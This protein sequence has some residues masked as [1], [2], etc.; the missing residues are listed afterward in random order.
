MNR[1]KIGIII[2]ILLVLLCIASL[3]I[4][5]WECSRFQK[6]VTAV[7]QAVEAGETALALA[8]YAELEEAW[9]HFRDISGLFVDGDRLDQPREVLAGIRP[10]IEAAHPEVLAELER[11]RV[12]TDSIYEEEIPSWA[13]LL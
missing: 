5:H 3:P 11:L 10:L 6:Q 2:L 7:M 8:E 4:L 12:L 13:H 9:P 1:C